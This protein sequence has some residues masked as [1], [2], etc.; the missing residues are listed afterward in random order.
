[1]M[2]LEF[3]FKKKT[4]INVVLKSSFNLTIKHQFHINN[5]LNVPN[6]SF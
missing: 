2:F 3:D 6:T 5:V 1:M 4:D